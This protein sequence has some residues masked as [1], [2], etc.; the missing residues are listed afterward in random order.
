MP[1][2]IATAEQTSAIRTGLSAMKSSVV[3]PDEAP[4]FP[5]A[6][7]FYHTRVFSAPALAAASAAEHDRDLRAAAQPQPGRGLLAD[8]LPATDAA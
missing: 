7:V 1:K 5:G 2:T 8:D 6:A 4:R 3:L